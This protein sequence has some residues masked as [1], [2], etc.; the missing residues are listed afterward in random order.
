MHFWTGFSDF[1]FWEGLAN[2]KLGRKKYTNLFETGSKKKDDSLN[3]K[4]L[5]QKRECD[6]LLA[7]ATVSCI[8]QANTNKTNKGTKNV[9]DSNDNEEQEDE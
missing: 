2:N 6:D 1:S 3:L 4:I 8:K 5:K 9:E 7:M